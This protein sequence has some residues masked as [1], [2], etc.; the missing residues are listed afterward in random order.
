MSRNIK[1]EIVEVPRFTTGFLKSL[2]G[3]GRLA[4]VNFT[5]KKD[6]SIRTLNGKALVKTALRG[7]EAAYDAE[8]RGQVRVVDVNIHTD[9]KGNK[10]PRTAEFRAVTVENINWVT[11]NGKKYIAVGGG[12]PVL[13]FVQGIT[14]NN[15]NKF[16]RLVLSG[17]T[18]IYW[19][20]PKSIHV[21]LIDA[22]NQGK[23]FNDNIKGVFEYTR[24]G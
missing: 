12:E 3:N 18:Y 6:G 15:L 19:N 9:R 8:S 10:I 1:R 23:Y 2:F 22:E 24:V 17:V 14:Y 7:G 20:V 13:N 5:K 21:G 11:A 16:L 4:T